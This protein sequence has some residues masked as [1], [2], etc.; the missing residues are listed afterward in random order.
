M[1]KAGLIAL[2]GFSSAVMPFIGIPNVAKVVLFVAFGLST[3]VLGLLVREER[4]WLLR[5]LKGDHR[6]DAYTENGAR[7]YNDAVKKTG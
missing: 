3:M 5:A 7:E 1:S 2:I 4:R 6:S